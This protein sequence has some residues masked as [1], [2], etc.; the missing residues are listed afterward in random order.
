[1][2]ARHVLGFFDNHGLLGARRLQW[3][4]VR[5]GSVAYVDAMLNR[6]GDAARLGLG[7][8]V[9]ERGL[10]GV[11][12]RDDA[13]RVHCFD[14]VVLATHADDALRLLAD[15]DPQERRVLSAF[16]YTE[17]DTVL[18]TDVRA[19]PPVPRSWSSWNAHVDDCRKPTTRPTVTYSLNR[20]Q[21]LDDAR[22]YCVTLN[23]PEAID[24]RRVIERATFSHP[25]FDDAAVTAQRRLPGIQRRRRTFFAGAYHGNGFH[26]DGLTSGLRAAEALAAAW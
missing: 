8:R 5:G 21:R 18:H 10:D 25:V 14:A 15:P 16:R 4:T 1:M 24:E 19:L 3:K 7:V 23:R 13:D 12:I 17:N 2:P 22:P 6:L 9:V 20:L 26:E 11:R